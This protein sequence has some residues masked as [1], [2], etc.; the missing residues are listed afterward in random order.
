[1]EQPSGRPEGPTEANGSD[2]HGIDDEILRRIRDVPPAAVYL[3]SVASAEQPRIVD[4][5]D[6]GLP[7]R[8]SDDP[9]DPGSHVI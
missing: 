6:P 4:P 7:S 9:L 3:D 8:D 5:L 1:M 2:M